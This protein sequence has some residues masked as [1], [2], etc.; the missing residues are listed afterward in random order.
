MR[1]QSGL[2]L[3]ELIT[4]LGVVLILAGLALPSLVAWRSNAAYRSAARQIVGAMRL[5]RSHA[6]TRTR[7]V[8]LDFDLDTQCYRL[9]VGNQAY[10]STAWS[11]MTPWIMLPRQVLLATTKD[12]DKR[13]DGD[14]TTP[15]IDTI[16]FN[17]NGT[18]GVFGSMAGN[19]VCVLSQDMRP[20]F[21]GAILSYTTGRAVVKTWDASRAEWSE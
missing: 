9:R 10:A 6:I 12:C 18:C 4:V 3:F 15:D 11:E 1:D 20:K 7:E 13:G 14:V 2:T 21:A 16:Q 19:Y 8:E 5:A 17:P